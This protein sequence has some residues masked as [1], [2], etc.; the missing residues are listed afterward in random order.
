MKNPFEEKNGIPINGKE[1]EFFDWARNQE[2]KR[3]EKLSEEEQERLKLADEHLAQ[4]M[5]S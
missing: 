4:K 5:N 2:L 3:R 1:K